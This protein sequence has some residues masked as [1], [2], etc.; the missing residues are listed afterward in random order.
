MENCEIDLMGECGHK[1]RSAVFSPCRRYRYELWR[2]WEDGPYC[3]FI[4]LN[5]STADSKKDDPT[6]RRCTR[7]AH[8]WG[9]AALCMTNLFAFQT[10][11][12]KIL[13]AA[14]DPIGP[15]NNGT[16]QRV[17]AGAGIVI[18]AWGTY[19]RYLRRGV[20]V[21]TMLPDLHCLHQTK[22]GMPGHP[23]YLRA[24]LM[25]RPFTLGTM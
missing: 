9:Y 1:T 24:D 19:G 20:T 15:E 11:D 17:A 7:F 16:L 8:D 6:I 12:P 4:G 25:P 5:P 10:P 22:D 21:A 23:L 13:M 14:E 3:M 18:A 2:R